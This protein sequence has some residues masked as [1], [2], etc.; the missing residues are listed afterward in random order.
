MALQGADC[1][2]C[3]YDSADQK[4]GS[5]R[6][7]SHDPSFQGTTALQPFDGQHS[8]DT[9]PSNQLVLIRA[10]EIQNGRPHFWHLR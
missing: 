8:P 5:E 9:L 4:D 3:D 1:K 6:C 10:G 2:R 7:D